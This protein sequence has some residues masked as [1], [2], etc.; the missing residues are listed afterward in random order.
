[1][2]REAH[3]PIPLWI[4]LVPDGSKDHPG[5]WSRSLLEGHHTLDRDIHPPYGAAAICPVCGARGRFDL[6]PT[7][8][9][10]FPDSIWVA[11]VSGE[12]QCVKCPK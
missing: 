8:K 3:D 6:G 9:P 1:M 7:S 12:A 11:Y 4:K 10:D 5:V 2:S